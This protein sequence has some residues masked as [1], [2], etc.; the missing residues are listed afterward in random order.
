MSG[1]VLITGMGCVSGLGHGVAANWRRARDG[2]GAIRP[3]PDP[4]GDTVAAWV[5]GEG[6]TGADTAFAN[7][8][9]ERLR[10]LGKLDP[11][12]T[13]AIEA[14]LEAVTAA[15]LMDYPTL[16]HRT[17]IVLGC[18]S[19]GNQT[20]EVAYER[21]FAKGQPRAHPQTIP[22][23]MMTA[24]AAQ[25]AILLG[26]HG[27]A[28]TI[29]SACASSAHALG[30]A[31]H[32]IRSG[33]VDVVLAGGAEA[34]LTR[35][36]L[37]GW[38]SLGVLAPD[39]CRPFSR[40]RRGMVLGEGAAVLVLESETHARARRA[41][42]LGELAG[43]GTSTDAAH[44]T[45]P[46]VGGISRAIGAALADAGVTDHAPMLIS[47]HGTGTPL[48]DPAETAALRAVC[49]KGLDRHRAIATKSAHGHMIGAAGAM[50]FV[51]GMAA[52]I[53]KEA[54]PV[55]NFLGADP[56]CDLPLVL[57]REKFAPEILLSNSFAFG[58]LNAVLVGRRA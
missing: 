18:G 15:N 17:A 54:P 44:M 26:V 3:L 1:R 25:I 20:R 19:G 22:S 5:E 11:L 16:A 30:E 37:A 23:S 7:V 38:Q 21:L 39:T 36:S 41:P 57:E 46:D 24:P 52:L 2:E 50:E 27:P 45:A 58:G 48:N 42:I 34:C 43:Y 14:A 56:D 13:F 33:R 28:F 55:L 53:E 35:G 9:P 47:T 31:M 4:L 51:I 29:S 10:R 6:G 8:D 49:G 40:D 32:M 12:S